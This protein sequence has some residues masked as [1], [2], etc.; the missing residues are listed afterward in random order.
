MPL[1]DAFFLTRL[2]SLRI[3]DKTTG[4]S[5]RVPCLC[6]VVRSPISLWKLTFS[7]SGNSKWF[8][9]QWLL[10]I[11]EIE[12][13]NTRILSRSPVDSHQ[14]IQTLPKLSGDGLSWGIQLDT[15]IFFCLHPLLRF[16]HHQTHLYM[17]INCQGA[18]WSLS[19]PIPTTCLICLF[20]FEFPVIH[21]EDQQVNFHYYFFPLIWGVHTYSYFLSCFTVD[22]SLSLSWRW[23]TKITGPLLQSLHFSKVFQCT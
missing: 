22:N 3:H 19:F 8:P 10:L 13:R 16:S 18:K 5:Q 1:Y 6:Q 12:V 15:S 7:E 14:V 9:I 2:I 11:K 17:R 4:K 23:G 21:H 20:Q